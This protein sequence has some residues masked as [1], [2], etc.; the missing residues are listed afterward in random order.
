LAANFEDPANASGIPPLPPYDLAIE[1]VVL[2][3]MIISG[4]SA[5]TVFETLTNDA[6]YSGA[7]RR[8]F[9]CMAELF[10]DATPID[11]ITL[12]EALRKKQWLESAGGEPYLAELAESIASSSNIS[13]YCDILLEKAAKRR[14]LDSILQVQQ[15]IHNEAPFDDITS[16][17]KETCLVVVKNDESSIFRPTW[18][19][20][21][22]DT[23]PLLT[24]N[25]TRICS[26]GNLTLLIAQHGAGKSTIGEVTCAARLSP[27]ADTF[28][29]KAIQKGLFFYVDTEQSRQDHSKLWL[30]TMKRAD[31]GRGIIPENLRFELIK[32]IPTLKMRLRYLDSIMASPELSLLILDGL[33]DF[34][35]DVNDPGECNEF[36]YWILSEA[37]KRDFGILSSIHHNPADTSG[38]K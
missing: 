15:M 29:L 11:I 30:R 17:L 21:P 7:N 9:I 38:K 4:R 16:L 20:I 31:I 12:A 23:P 3:S 1:R 22:P 19:N 33:A 32:M 18:D 14:L 36:L 6:F 26:A 13:Y 34:V 25:N 24:L 27:S 35:K 28:G 37:T 10:K 5:T 8:I 2:G